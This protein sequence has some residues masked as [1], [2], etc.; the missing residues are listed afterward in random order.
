MRHPYS[1]TTAFLRQRGFSVVEMLVAMTLSLIVLAGVLAVMLSSKVTY[2]ENERVGRIQENGR[3]ALELML[4][5]LRGAGF[6]GCA[7]PIPGL[8][9]MNNMLTSPTSVAWNL[10]QPV[11][12][13]EGSAG[14]WAP[15]ATSCVG[16]PGGG[17]E[18]V[19][20]GSPL[21]GCRVTPAGIRLTMRP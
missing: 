10:T 19:P 2:A 9:D 13:S 7:Q 21:A 20:L 18:G 5:D 16:N 15:T 14:A 11:Y 1:S 6:P 8:F 17:G 4:R 3:A 12:G